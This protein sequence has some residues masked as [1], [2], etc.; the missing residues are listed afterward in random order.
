MHCTIVYRNKKGI[1]YGS[2]PYLVLVGATGA[3]LTDFVN[4]RTSNEKFMF[5]R[6]QIKLLRIID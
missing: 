4:T 2:P 3:S 1:V 6:L 5:Q